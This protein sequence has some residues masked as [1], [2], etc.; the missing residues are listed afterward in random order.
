MNSRSGTWDA[1]ELPVESVSRTRQAFVTQIGWRI[2]P[3]PR[4]ALQAGLM[5]CVSIHAFALGGDSGARGD[6]NLE[7]PLEIAVPLGRRFEHVG[8]PGSGAAVVSAG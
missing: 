8:E 2:Q 1:T 6:L 3:R 7:L 4:L 5:A